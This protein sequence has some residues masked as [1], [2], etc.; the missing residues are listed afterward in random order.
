VALDNPTPRFAAV[1]A[2]PAFNEL[3]RFSI[4]HLGV[5]PS[6]PPDRRDADA[7]NP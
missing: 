4:A 6:L 3:T 2:A 7:E 5:P 1:T